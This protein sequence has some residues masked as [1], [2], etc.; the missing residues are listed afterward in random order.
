ME[1]YI[2]YCIDNYN[3]RSG[4]GASNALRFLITRNSKLYNYK[5]YCKNYNKGDLQDIIPEIATGKEIVDEFVKGDYKCIHWL[6]AESCELYLE[7]IKEIKSRKLEIPIISTICQQPDAPGFFLGPMEVKYP[8]RIVFIDDTAYNNYNFR[9]IPSSR[10]LMLRFGGLSKETFENADRILNSIGKGK[11]DTIV[12]GRGSSLNKCPKN[13]FDIFDRIAYPKK[14][15]IVGKG[16]MDWIQKEISKRDYEIILL[17]SMPYNQWLETVAT[18]DIFL[19]HLPMEAYSSTD[20]TMMNAMLMK[21]PVVYLGPDAPREILVDNVNARIAQSEEQLVK[22]CNELAK[23]EQERIRL[24]ENAR[25]TCEQFQTCEQFFETINR[26]YDN[27]KPSSP[28]RLSLFYLYAYL[29]Y[30]Y[31]QGKKWPWHDEQLYVF[32]RI[33]DFRR[34]FAIKT[35]IRSMLFQDRT[36]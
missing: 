4:A 21:K 31:R 2:I 16:E 27:I 25:K 6:R 19:Y 18:F 20:G 36:K 14:F 9:F 17:D 5:L 7:M 35:R 8:S 13:M 32:S 10:K 12:Y 30:K 15:I 22:Y 28:I 34:R 3:G 24:G 33:N 26:L 11:N 23:N 1:N 29:T